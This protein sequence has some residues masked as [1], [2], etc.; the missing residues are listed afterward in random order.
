MLALPMLL[1][2]LIASPPQDSPRPARERSRDF[3]LTYRAIVRDI[4]ADVR[5]LDLWLPVPQTDRHQTIHQLTIDS[6]VAPTIGREER[7]G[8]HGLHVRIAT[9]RG[10]IA[11]AWTARVTR[12]ENGG[13]DKRLSDEERALDLVW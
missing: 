13:I 2:A 5:T 10:A 3:V 11:M 1:V 4:P 8:N 6:P 12:R 7:F 9:P